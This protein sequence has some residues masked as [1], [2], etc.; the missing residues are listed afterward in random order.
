MKN[1]TK[2]LLVLGFAG[3]LVVGYLLGVVVDFPKLSNDELAGTIGKVNKYKKTVMTQKDVELRNSLAKDTAKLSEMIDGLIGF[4]VLTDRVGK[5]I[6]KALLVY[7]LKG[8]DQLPEGKSRLEALQSYAALIANNNRDLQGTV[9][10]LGDLYANK[11]TDL[12]VDMENRLKDLRSFFASLS[13]RSDDLSLGLAALDNFM[14]G[15]AE[16]KSNPKTLLELKSLRDQLALS[17]LQLAAVLQSKEL[18]AGLVNNILDN[19]PKLCLLSSDKGL[20]ALSTETQKL[21]NLV[22]SGEQLKLGAVASSANTPDGNQLAL[23][24]NAGQLA[25]LPGSSQLPSSDNGLKVVM[26]VSDQ[27]LNVL[28]S[29]LTLDDIV[30]AGFNSDALKDLYLFAM[31]DGSLSVGLGLNSLGGNLNSQDLGSTL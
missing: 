13:Q 27:Q 3:T 4:S 20:G 11:D 21:K 22:D 8:M 30:G 25:F 5:G 12:S 19:E 1:R 28:F 2:G 7:R 23:L 16:L 17:S 29:Q 15:D 31:D 9:A 10:L 6:D 26:A 24:Y 14:L 18:A